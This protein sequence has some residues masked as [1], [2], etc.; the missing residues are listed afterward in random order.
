MK[1]PKYI[2]LAMLV[3][4]FICL[5]L[6]VFLTIKDKAPVNKYPDI[7]TTTPIKP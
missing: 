7:I 1:C 4:G 6:A 5:G 2:V 3:G